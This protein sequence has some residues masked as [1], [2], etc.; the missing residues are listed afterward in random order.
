ML[1]ERAAKVDELLLRYDAMLII[2]I[3]FMYG[4][5]IAGP[6]IFGMGRVPA[7]RFAIFNFIGA[8]IWAVLVAS[9]GFVLGQ[10]IELVLADHK[11]FELAVFAVIALAGVVLWAVYRF[12]R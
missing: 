6:I 4:F 3:R 12:R 5:R 1:S 11:R 7:A 9:I 2:A 10:T 8:C